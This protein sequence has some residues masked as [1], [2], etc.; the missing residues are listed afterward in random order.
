MSLRTVILAF[1]AARYPAAY[2][3]TAIL[4]RINL[5][6]LLDTRAT[7]DAVQVELRLLANKFN[8]VVPELDETTG[9]LY[10]TATDAG[11]KR[12]HLDGAVHVG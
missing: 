7:L 5:C 9:D 2:A 3:D 4:V 6:G 1:L 8:F 10:W 11:V 12:W